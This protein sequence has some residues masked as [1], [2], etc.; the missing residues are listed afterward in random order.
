MARNFDGVFNPG[1]SEAADRGGTASTTTSDGCERDGLV[2][3]LQFVDAI[4]RAAKSTQL[5]AE[6]NIGALA[7]QQLDRRLDQNRAQALAR[8]QRPAGLPAGEQRLPHDGAGKAGRSL[9]ADRH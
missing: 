6:A 8:N 9:P 7:L 1:S 3:E 2:A 4:S 5:L